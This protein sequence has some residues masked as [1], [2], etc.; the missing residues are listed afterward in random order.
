MGSKVTKIAIWAHM[1]SMRQG[2]R[3]KVRVRGLETMRETERE[4]IETLRV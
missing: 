4:I 2:D 3:V 1:I